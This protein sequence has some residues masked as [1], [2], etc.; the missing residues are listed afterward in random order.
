[1]RTR[2][3]W[4]VL[5]GA[6]LLSPAAVQG[7]TMNYE[8]PPSMSLFPGPIGHARM[9]EGG[10][11]VAGRFLFWNQT[12]PIRDQVVAVRGFVDVVGF[13]D[14][15]PGTFI[16]SG[17][18]ALNTQ[19]VSG[20]GTFQPGFDL[21]MGW[22]FEDGV[23]VQTNWIHL[24]EARYSA[25][26]TLAPPGLKSGPSMADNFLYS[27]VFNFPADYA[28]NAFNIDTSSIS[29]TFVPGITFGIW[30]A[31]SLMTIE[32]VQRFDQWDLT[33]RFPIW[34]TDRHRTY[35]LIG[36]RLVWMWER[37]RWRTVDMD[38][39]GGAGPD[40]TAIYSNVVSQRLYGV[41]GGCGH[42]WFLGDTPIGAFS[43]SL[44]CEM[45]LF[46]NF[47]KERA[48]Y[49]L[50][51]RSTA[52]TRSRNVWTMVPELQAKLSSWWY[53]LEAVQVC[54]SYDVMSFFNTVASPQP[55]DFNFGAIAPAWEQWH[56]RLFQGIGFGIGIIF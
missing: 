16:G 17:A 26:A 53:P 13:L 29:S 30:N 32:F 7:Q 46:A 42:E 34:E 6:L 1:M 18:V 4:V 54:L 24:W 8:V 12:N 3:G 10:F 5:A 23:V 48:R 35:F 27:P 22:R 21:T 43:V 44:D 2:I 28:G 20:P 14:P 52:A 15:T 47:V 45:G 49:E 25:T 39:E 41:H 36:P 51:D 40:T 11:F 55:I 9:E 33:G 37:F 31:A 38:V 19:Q 50:A 56:T